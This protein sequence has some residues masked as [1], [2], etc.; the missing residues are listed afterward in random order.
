MPKHAPALLALVLACIL[1]ASCT[2]PQPA[3]GVR[4]LSTSKSWVV[5]CEKLDGELSHV[6]PKTSGRPNEIR[7]LFTEDSGELILQVEQAD[8]V[9][10]V[11]VRDGTVSIADWAD[12]DVT[13]RIIGREAANIDVTFSWD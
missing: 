1:L 7:T 13:L 9:V 12:G 3:M 4:T 11:P 10:V 5:T 2:I 8:K 6:I